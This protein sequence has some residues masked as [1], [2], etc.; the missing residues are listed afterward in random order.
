MQDLHTNDHDAATVDDLL[1]QAALKW[2][3]DVAIIWQPIGAENA[4]SWTYAM[5]NAQ[6]DRVTHHLLGYCTPGEHIAIWAPNSPEWV[7]LEFAAARAGLVLV[8]INPALQTRELS[9]ILRQSKSKLLAHA[10]IFRGNAM[11]AIAHA[12]ADQLPELRHLINIADLGRWPNMSASP[13]PSLTTGPIAQIQYTSGT[14]GNPKGVLLRHEAIAK[15]AL[16]SFER[17]EIK[18]DDRLLV[19]MPLFHTMGCG[20][21]VLGAIQSGAPMIM[22]PFFDPILVNRAISTY[23]ATVFFGVPTM[24]IAM[25]DHN[26]RE[27]EMLHSLRLICSGGTTVPAEIVDRAIEELGV[28][29]SIGYGQTEASPLIAQTGPV[30]LGRSSRY[31]VG[32]PLPEIEVAIKSIA[33]PSDANATANVIGEICVRGYNVM[34]GYHDNLPA[35]R[36]AVDTEGWLHTGDLGFFDTE[37]YLHVTGRTKDM[38]IRGGENIYPAEIENVMLEHPDILEAAVVGVPHPVH[39]EVPVCFVRLRSE[40]I[41]DSESLKRYCR[42]NLSAQKTPAEW[43]AI[44]QL[45]FTAS[46][47]VQKFLLREQYITNHNKM[48]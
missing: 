4:E 20:I 16:A 18:K 28:Q 6:V 24:L 19:V 34:A 9:Y 33:A 35:T 3:D 7:I 42:E 22:L 17:M 38:L 11:E 14:T 48:V 26:Q 2:P 25:L 43:I 44:S 13:I 40:A 31:S 5:L 41:L 36:A 23:R 8:T 1:A 27:P 46:G 39:G 10:T 12:V 15:N 29:F 30:D 45:P 21:L 47:K 32:K 37:G